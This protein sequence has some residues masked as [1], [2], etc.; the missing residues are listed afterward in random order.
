[1]I[2]SVLAE[3]MRPAAT[4]VI[5][6]S[7]PAAPTLTTLVGDVPL[8]VYVTPP[9]VA[10]DVGFGAAVVEPE[11][12]ATSPALFATADA[13]NATAPAAAAVDVLPSASE[14]VP[15]AT[16]ELPIATAPSPFAVLFDPAVTAPVPIAVLGSPIATAPLP[17]TV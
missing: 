14:P 15:C 6:R 9:I 2:A 17:L 10:L 7:V 1:M 13:P 8:N 5:C 12:S 16:F 3:L 11:P 4:L